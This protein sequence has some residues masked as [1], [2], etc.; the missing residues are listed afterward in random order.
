MM[1]RINCTH[2]VSKRTQNISVFFFLFFW[3]LCNDMGVVAILTV[4]HEGELL[5]LQ[6]WHDHSVRSTQIIIAVCLPHD[7]LNACVI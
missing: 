4:M 1:S 6:I 5:Y 3:P 7:N 2:K